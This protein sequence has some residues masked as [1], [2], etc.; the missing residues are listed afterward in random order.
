MSTISGSAASDRS[1]VLV[2][3]FPFRLQASAGLEERARQVGTRCAAASQLLGEALGRRPEF[4]VRV[5][6]ERDWPTGEDRPY[7]MPHYTAG[8]VVVAG[9]ESAFWRS[10]VPFLEQAPPDAYQTAAEVYGGDL[11]L[12]AFFDLLAVHEVGHAF[13]QDGRGPSGPRWLHEVFANI[14]LHTYVAEVEPDNMPVL[15][16]FPRA[17]TAVE[18]VPAAFPR[19]TLAEFEAHYSSMGGLN[20]GWYQCHFHVAA[21]RVHDTGGVRAMQRLWRRLALSDGELAEVLRAEVD[22]EVGAAF[23]GSIH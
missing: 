19:R 8:T 20:Y 14:C 7:G 16:A 12:G 17:L 9:E 23:A 21:G 18:P 22:G 6:A 10:F 4:G 15:E 3:G 5:L 11:H 13:H 1:L 2:P